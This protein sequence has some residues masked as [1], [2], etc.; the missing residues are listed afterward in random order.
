MPNPR[1]PGEGSAA[2]PAAG[3]RYVGMRRRVV[4]SL[5]GEMICDECGTAFDEDRCPTCAQ[6]NRRRA[7][8]ESVVET[9]GGR[10]VWVTME[11]ADEDD[12]GGWWPVRARSAD[13]EDQADDEPGGWPW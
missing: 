10:R 1:F 11:R 4:T 5:R 6:R 8:L 12:G 13:A 2:T 7:G 9:Y 3:S